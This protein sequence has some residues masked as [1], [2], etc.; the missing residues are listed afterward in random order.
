MASTTSGPTPACGAPARHGVARSRHLRH[1]CS[2]STA[3]A[4]P[5]P[6]PCTRCAA[7]SSSRPPT[8]LGAASVAEAGGLPFPS[9]STTAKACSPSS[10][11]SPPPR[12]CYRRSSTTP[13]CSPRSSSCLTPL[14]T[15]SPPPPSATS[16]G[17]PTSPRGPG[18]GP[19]LTASVLPPETSSSMS[20]TIKM[21]WFTASLGL[22]M[23][24]CSTYRNAAAAN[25]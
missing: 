20:S 16:T 3:T 23:F 11:Q 15:T 6:T 9:A 12:F 4:R 5:A 8:R 2:S 19:S 22:G 13:A 24:M 7:P 10:T 14:G 25:P 17:S 1:R 18:G 21:V